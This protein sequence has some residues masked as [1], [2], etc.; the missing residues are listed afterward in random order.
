MNEF[1]IIKFPITRIVL[2]EKRIKTVN[3]MKQ[4]LKQEFS[5]CSFYRY[6]KDE[7]IIFLID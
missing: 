2:V 3:Q 5:E 6:C 4:F 1:K 7:Q